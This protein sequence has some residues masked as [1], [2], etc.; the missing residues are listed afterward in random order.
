[1]R[2]ILVAILKIGIMSEKLKVNEW[3]SGE[4]R[5]RTIEDGFPP[6]ARELPEITSSVQESQ[7]ISLDIQEFNAENKC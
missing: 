6:S 3:I 4:F 7:L 1:M 2:R 5:S